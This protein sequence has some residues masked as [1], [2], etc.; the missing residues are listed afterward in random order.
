M[1]DHDPAS[2]FTGFVNALRVVPPSLYLRS[3]VFRFDHP[4]LS[5]ESRTWISRALLPPSSIFSRRS[6]HAFWLPSRPQPSP[7][8][9]PLAARAGWPVMPRPAGPT[10]APRRQV[11]VATTWVADAVT[12]SPDTVIISSNENPLGPAACALDAPLAMPLRKRVA[13]T[14]SEYTTGHD[15]GHQRAV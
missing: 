12:M 11:P 5:E 8:C 3:V 7:P 9:P 2:S 6:F 4:V 13:V 10:H 15:Q 14:T 1:V